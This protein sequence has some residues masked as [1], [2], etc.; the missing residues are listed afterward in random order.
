MARRVGMRV[1]VFSI[2]FGKPLYS[3]MKDGVKW[4]L[5]WLPFGGYVKIAGTDE[6]TKED[7]YT[8]ADGFY[9]KGPW[10]RIKV[11]FMGPAVNL[12]FALFLFGLIWAAGGREKPF[13]ETTAKI[14]WV[15]PSS[16]LYSKGVRPGDEIISYN[17]KPFT[18]IKDHLY[19]ILLSRNE[20]LVRGN[21]V[22]YATKGK[23]PFEYSVAPKTG[24]EQNKQM[25]L[26]PANYLMYSPLMTKYF[27]NTP[28][29]KS[30]IEPT[31]RLIWVDG[32]LIFSTPQ[33]QSVLNDG[34]ALLTIERG[35]DT[36]LMRVPRVEAEELKFTAES[37]EE[38][39]DWQYEA[40]LK[41]EK[42]S[43]LFTI[44]YN[45]NN[46]AVVEGELH[47]IDKDKEQETFE[48][49]AF[50]PLEAPLQAGDRIIAIDGQPITRSYE[51]LRGLQNRSIHIIVERSASINENIPAADADTDFDKH[52]ELK[53]IN[54][55]AATIGTKK[56]LSSAG[57]YILLAPVVPQKEIDLVRENPTALLA[58]AEAKEKALKSI[59]DKEKRAQVEQH[60]RQQQNRLAIGF[61]AADR[62][63]QYN[64][65]PGKMFYD[66]VD[67]IWFTLQGL[68]S[69]SLSPK[70]LSGP[71]GIVQVVQNTWS[72]GIKEALF[73]IGV[74]S[75]NL[76]VMNLLPI[77][78]LD[79][80][81]I[82]LSFAELITGRRVP[83][84][85]LEKIVVP[86]A[87]L[88]IGFF[89][90]ITYHDLLRL[91]GRFW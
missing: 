46:E 81:T 2:G 26:S 35:N 12:V 24:S 71:I 74:I 73:W 31:D 63:V 90:F 54:A 72:V 82:V 91:L 77:P 57:S 25:L 69:G 76:G 78:V 27:K 36:L 21:H 88:L 42:W 62:K 38:L 3:W 17:E 53:D 83:P 80:G 16:E 37:K 79:G 44:P 40:D 67:E 66:V 84:K 56:L 86:F 65:S 32:E 29:E 55:I 75:L 60:F 8:V 19:A 89:I 70:L 59:D 47:F 5:G 11:A 4:Q 43:N 33:L 61:V 64:P 52:L 14:G 13:A 9:G 20:I 1:E 34:K 39:I 30:G 23:R 58:E 15:D 7:P 10:N 51:L 49:T 41:A 48:R 45:L 50:S 28:I 85:I 68:F 87:L 22:D 6:S 18:G